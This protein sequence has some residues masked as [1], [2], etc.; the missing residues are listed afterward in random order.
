MEVSIVDEIDANEQSEDLIKEKLAGAVD[1]GK[2]VK[3]R[4][5]TD[6]RV[7]ARITDGIYRD[8]ASALRELI[9][10]GY[11]ADATEVRV[12][13]DFP[14]FSKI[15]VRDNGKGLTKETLAH[16]ICHIGGSL[17]R[18]KLGQSHQV[19]S[20]TDVSKSPS[21]RSLIGKLGIGLFSVSQ[22]T[23]HVVII[24]K[25][26]GDNKRIYC[27][28]LLMP[29]SEALLATEEGQQ[30]VTGK[31]EIKFV[32]AV[33]LDSHGTEILL[34][35]LRSHV[36]ESLLSKMTWDSLKEKAEN[37]SKE[38]EIEQEAE[39]AV[40][41][42]DNDA[43]ESG[44]NIVEPLFHIGEIDVQ[45]GQIVKPPSLP[46]GPDAGPDQKFPELVEKLFSAID[47][48]DRSSKVPSI[49]EHLDYYLRMLWVLSLS[50][51]LPYLKKH[52]FEVSGGDDALIYQIDNKRKLPSPV[53][54]S[55]GEAETVVDRYRFKSIQTLD[56]PFSVYVDGVKL[57]R[58]LK[59]GKFQPLDYII[60]KP[61]LFVGRAKPDLSEIPE[62]YR[63]GEL[64]FEAYLYWTRKIVPKEH[65]GVLIR[66]NGA[67]G[68]LFD[69]TFLKYQVSE[70]TRLRQISAE[71]YVIKGLDA[72]LNIDR[73]SFNIS[74][75]HYQ[76]IRNWLHSAMRQLMNKHK[77]LSGSVNKTVLAAQKEKTFA[78]LRQIVAA[79]EQYSPGGEVK[80][81]IYLTEE[82]SLFSTQ[83]VNSVLEL[84]RERV[85]API[86]KD[87]GKSAKEKARQIL[88]EEKAKSLASILAIYGID[89]HLSK[90]QFESLIS[91]ILEVM[92][93]EIKK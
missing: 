45:N 80:E 58:P 76:I 64:E 73:E 51:P 79:Q 7:F 66:I 44:I 53:E 3:A 25:T 71:I 54:V 49:Q 14:R 69:E 30:F 61:M 77:L 82:S 85:L 81:I 74:H 19:S 22:I 89:E 17:K 13:T 40:A 67:S 36:K 92:V 6:E 38:K 34:L 12:E 28:I 9:A 87:R 33:D 16:V 57:Y 5:M 86:L 20:D 4:L 52:P 93:L 46:W 56:L 15:S 41:Y 39:L 70:Q 48:D 83:D 8:P 2:V 27:D 72:A 62:Q 26:K 37:E 91:A 42:D 75:P 24:S 29:Q 10:N 59:F 43:F 35:D 88:N 84:R 32:D 23:H 11:D 47:P 18:T 60:N 55:L 65:N 31:V 90:D 1:S 63:G 21:G 78:Q 68:T 50:L